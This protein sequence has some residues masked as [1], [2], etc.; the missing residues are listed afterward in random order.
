MF[1]FNLNLGRISNC[2]AAAFAFLLTSQVGAFAS[3]EQQMPVTMQASK[4]EVKR[5]RVDIFSQHAVDY[6]PA[7]A[8]SYNNAAKSRW[9]DEPGLNI[10]VFNTA[11][12]LWREILRSTTGRT[13]ETQ[14]HDFVMTQYFPSASLNGKTSPLCFI[15]FNG[16][17]TAELDAY[18]TLYPSGYADL[19][20]YLH[21]LGHCL[22]FDVSR[23]EKTSWTLNPRKDELVADAFAIAYFL[24]AK[25]P[26]AVDDIMAQQTGLSGVD[27]HKDVG[28]RE[29]FIAKW[30]AYLSS[31]TIPSNA[32]ELFQK[33]R[34]ILKDQEAEI[35]R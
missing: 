26:A 21:E 22:F 10:Q 14:D 16:E 20:L 24:Q 35:T 30:R 34:T 29:K 8:T 1:H 19:Y 11:S 31:S 2:S 18:D 9:P 3:T 13:Y 5:P 23:R 15:G 28:S 33:M 25:I 6:I 7:I 27:P 12:P 32:L 17:R 4:K